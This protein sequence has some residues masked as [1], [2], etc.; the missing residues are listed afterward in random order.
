MVKR[1]ALGQYFTP[2]PIADFMVSL[3]CD[4][5]T[6]NLLDPAVGHG[7]F[8]DRA[9]AL[10]PTADMVACDIDGTFVSEV[11]LNHVE[12]KIYHQDYLTMSFEN[13]FQAIVC[14]PPYNKFHNVRERDSL[15]KRF[16]ELYHISLSG[17]TNM[18]AFFMLKSLHELQPGG[19]CCYI[20]PYEFFNTGYGVTVKEY[21]LR[22]KMLKYVIRFNNSINLFEDAVTTSCILLFE[23]LDHDSVDFIDITSIEDIDNFWK[24]SPKSK[25]LLYED[26]SA[27]IKWSRYFEGDITEHVVSCANTVPLNYFAQVK[28]GIATGDNAFF[29]LNK[30]SVER[31]GLSKS[32][33]VPCIAKSA[34]ITS[35]FLTEKLYHSL[36]EANKK[37]YLFDG[38]KA[39]NEC[40]VDY[41]RKGEQAGVNLRYLTKHRKP[42]YSIENRIPAPIL[43]SVFSR[44]RIKVVRNEANI[45]S[46][47]TFHGLYLLDLYEQYTNILFCYLLTPIAQQILYRNKREYGD[48]L[49]K[50][51]PNDLNNAEILNFLVMNERDKQIVSQ[52]Y[53]RLR[54]EEKPEYIVQLNE[55]FSAYLCV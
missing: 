9:R 6:K 54:I 30:E 46:L 5:Y 33:C 37:V 2:E 51:E 24:I 11:Q 20:I 17:Y 19:K 16:N 53:E 13:K 31:L 45:H 50:F 23:H 18:Y 41:I 49:D 52:L 47:T 34:D 42:W 25:R 7:I 12:A 55:L 38:A 44:G 28:R 22:S 4:K 40:D 1:K 39:Y 29:A 35:V 36:V 43:L 48:G 3:V 14:N 21:L 26:V 8:L 15:I 10:S 32:V 27:E